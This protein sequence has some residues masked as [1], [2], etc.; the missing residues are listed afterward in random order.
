M[1]AD[2]SHCRLPECITIPQPPMF[3]FFLRISFF[4]FY[5]RLLPVSVSA[6]LLHWGHRP[7]SVLYYSVVLG[8]VVGSRV[9]GAFLSPFFIRISVA[10][11]TFCMLMI[12]HELSNR[13]ECIPTASWGGPHRLCLLARISRDSRCSLVFFSYCYYYFTSSHRRHL[14]TARCA[15]VKKRN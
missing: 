13:T 14:F 6:I 15:S 8:T 10:S 7:I 9:R 2:P 11:R 4:F 5:S 3:P 1:R 12:L